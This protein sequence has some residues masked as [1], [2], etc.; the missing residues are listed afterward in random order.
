MSL[1][2]INE[3]FQSVAIGAQHHPAKDYDVSLSEDADNKFMFSRIDYSTVSTQWDNN[4]TG[5][6]LKKSR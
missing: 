1:D 2:I 3:F 5:N 4:L 6:F